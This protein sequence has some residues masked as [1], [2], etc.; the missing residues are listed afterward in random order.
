M[1]P[2]TS[3]RKRGKPKLLVTLSPSHH[4]FQRFAND[5]RLAGLRM[6][7]PML[8]VDEV[9]AELETLVTKPTKVPVFFDV[10]GR[11]L[12]VMEEVENDQF[13]DIRLNHPIE[14]ETPTVVITKGG[15]DA[16]EV[17]TL[18]EGG[19]RLVF[20]KNPQWRVKMGESIHILDPNHRVLPPLFHEDE[21]E[22]IA[23]VKAAG[24]IK[25]WFLSYVEEQRDID[26]LREIIGPDDEI[27]L[28]IE[29]KRGLQFVAEQYKPSPRTRL[30]AACGDLFV[31]VG[32]PHKILNAVKLI[33]ARDPRAIVGS[34]ML[35]SLVYS[36]TPSFADLTQLAWLRDIG[37]D[38]FMLCDELCLKED[39][40]AAALN[41]FEAFRGE[42]E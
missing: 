17:G 5:T 38:T 41:V 40:L 26:Q 29:S 28:K 12:R 33:S 37:Y 32:Q 7:T 18:L 27:L 21:Q 19:K 8:T 14:V 36:S 20:S 25:K 4:H 31:E 34:R 6:N 16:G 42:C 30:V 2:F 22:K 15:N 3:A 24:V 39:S 1:W 9:V 11:Q 35:L 13:C 10:K 23:A